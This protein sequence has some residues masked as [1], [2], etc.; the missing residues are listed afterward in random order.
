M[1]RFTL[2]AL[3]L[4]LLVSCQKYR[5]DVA[6]EFKVEMNTVSGTRAR[7]TVG[8]RNPRAFY[9]YCL[10]SQDDE[11]YKQ[12]PLSFC[13]DM[14]VRME[15]GMS[16]MEDASFTDVF[17]YR[18]SR[19]FTLSLQSDKDFKIYIFQLHPRTH[20]ILG[21][22]IVEA[23]H[24]R[25]V[26][27]RDLHFEFQVEGDVLTII[28]SSDEY[29][30]YWDYE[31]TAV[32]NANYGFPLSF[33]EETITM[34]DEYGFLENMYS[35]GRETWN[36]TLND[37]TLRPGEEDTLLICGCENGDITSGHVEVYFR[38]NPGQVE[39]LEIRDFSYD[40]KDTP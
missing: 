20:E 37:N 36:F 40:P 12:D 34:Y 29:T 38:Y 30:Y 26:P 10:V 27:R 15:E 4:C 23:F 31:E 7:F 13:R 3:A 1:K 21:D 9:T 16:Y 5:D 28:P 25:P 11:N 33:L 6:A 17:C 14:V 2:L 18:G 39:I 22:V 8:A 35:Q 24:T 32:I 19:Q